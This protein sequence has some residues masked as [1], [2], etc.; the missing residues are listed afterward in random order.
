MSGRM[1]AIWTLLAEHKWP[2]LS[3]FTVA[4]VIERALLAATDPDGEADAVAPLSPVRA[5]QILLDAAAAKVGTATRHRAL[6][7]RHDL[8]GLESGRDLLTRIG[9][10]PSRDRGMLRCPAHDDRRAS[11]SWRLGADGRALLHDFGGCSFDE[12][13]AAAS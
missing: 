3:P 1:P 11:L 2:P 4:V 5:R 8:Q 9:A 6:L 13:L 10:N 12:I 7:P